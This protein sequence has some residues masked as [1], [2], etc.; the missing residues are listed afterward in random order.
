MRQNFVPQWSSS[1]ASLGF[2]Y[3]LVKSFASYKGN[4]DGGFSKMIA[5]GIDAERDMIPKYKN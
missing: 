5:Y 1:L 2:I 3:E 4:L